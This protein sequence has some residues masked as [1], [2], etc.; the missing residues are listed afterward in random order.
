[1]QN[2][3]IFFVFF[4]CE[5]QVGRFNFIIIYKY[6][7][8]NMVLYGIYILL[9]QIYF[10]CDFRVVDRDDFNEKYFMGLILFS[11]FIF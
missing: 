11:I 4:V 1:M 9:E 10:G 3:E 5:F 6:I 2:Y 7:F 8:Y